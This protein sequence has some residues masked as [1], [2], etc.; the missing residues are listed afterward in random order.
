MLGFE[1][2]SNGSSIS[3]SSTSSSA[4]LVSMAF[5]HAVGFVDFQWPEESEES[6]SFTPA[7]SEVEEEL[8]AV[9]GII[10]TPPQPLFFTGLVPD[11]GFV[12][13]RESAGFNVKIEPGSRVKAA[14]WTVSVVFL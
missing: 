14:P 8:N 4:D 6:S 1:D 5:N 7:Q 11:L 9:P 10:I 12:V 13:E 3:P 2:S